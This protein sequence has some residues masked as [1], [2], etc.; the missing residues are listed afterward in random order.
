MRKTEYI[1]Q[2][3]IVP[4]MAKWYKSQA[5]SV[6]NIASNFASKLICESR[7]SENV[8]ISY[9][10]S[11]DW[12][13]SAASVSVVRGR[14]EDASPWALCVCVCVSVWVSVCVC[15]WSLI[16]LTYK[17]IFSLQA[18]TQTEIKL[19]LRTRWTRH[20]KHNGQKVKGWRVG[21]GH[22]PLSW[23]R[24]RL[25]MLLSPNTFRKYQDAELTL[26]FVETQSV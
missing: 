24:M 11:L 5:T 16:V 22:S 3:E 4:Q 1:I 13:A 12:D 19:M 9:L 18:H 10:Q 15:V 20:R 25:Y 2:P 23:P 21:D 14:S 26:K 17:T 7:K 8:L 6:F